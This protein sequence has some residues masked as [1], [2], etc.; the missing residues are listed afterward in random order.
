MANE[1]LSPSA[2]PLGTSFRRNVNEPLDTSSVFSLLA[3]AETYAHNIAANENYCPYDGQI[4]TVRQGS[5]N[6][7]HIYKLV[8]ANGEEDWLDGYDTSKD[9]NADGILNKFHYNLIEILGADRTLDTK[10]GGTVEGPVNF[11]GGATATNLL[12]TGTLQVN[13]VNINH[14]KHSGG[15]FLNT[16]ANIVVSEVTEL[17][18]ADHGKTKL[19]F[20]RTAG[21]QTIYNLF[22]KGDFALSMMFNLK[23]TKGYQIGNDGSMTW[24]AGDG[25]TLIDVVRYYWREVVD[26]DSES[27][28]L[29]AVPNNVNMSAPKVGDNVVQLGNKTDVSRQG[30]QVMGYSKTN[31]VFIAEYDGLTTNIKDSKANNLAKAVF[32]DYYNAIVYLSP[33]KHK[34]QGDEIKFKFGQNYISLADTITTMAGDI[35]TNAN[36]IQT[37]ANNIALKANTAT[38]NAAIADIRAGNV[39]L[40]TIPASGSS[41]ARVELQ[42]LNSDGTAMANLGGALV[43]GTDGSVQGVMN[44]TSGSVNYNDGFKL[45]AKNIDFTADAINLNTTRFVVGTET[46]LLLETVYDEET[47]EYTTFIRTDLLNV[48]ALQAQSVEAAKIK[49]TEIV[50]AALIESATFDADQATI[51]NLKVTGD[52]TFQGNLD[53]VGGT[54]SGDLAAAGGTFK[55]SIRIADGK[56][57]IDGN[58]V[59]QVTSDATQMHI[60]VNGLIAKAVNALNKYLLA[61]TDGIEMRWINDGLRLSQNGLERYDG[62]KWV[63]MFSEEKAR[64]I[65][66]ATTLDVKDG[67]VV[68]TKMES[69]YTVTLPPTSTELVDGKTIQIIATD[70]TKNHYIVVKPNSN[71]QITTSAAGNNENGGRKLLHANRC[72]VTYLNGFWHFSA[73]GGSD[74]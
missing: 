47:D 40:V 55:G 27:I 21:G 11:D 19:T 57:L 16:R 50:S 59:N 42:A 31:G 61:N 35:I 33:K 49:A 45:K 18:G 69:H 52:S 26:V 41:P 37:N 44:L 70:T 10:E 29:G 20:T 53:G 7:S 72:W 8:P 74:A 38:L 24:N 17:T 67:I 25:E 6:E 22:E 30:C 34:L 48:K 1:I 4:I 54:F 15:V 39:R 73:T 65:E 5:D 71:Q 43:F 32:D 28:T 23:E 56:V 9:Y 60:G 62:S 3:E 14:I 68:C 64:T 63:N 13:E 58:Q 51:Q 46:K 2:M 36:N 66:G 12:V